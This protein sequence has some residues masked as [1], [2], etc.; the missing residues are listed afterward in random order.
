MKQNEKAC[1]RCAE[2][3]KLDALV[4]KHCGYEFSP[5]EMAAA[6]DAK[7][8][9]QRKSLFGCLGC[10]GLIAI[11]AVIAAVS[12]SGDGSSSSTED[13]KA[14]FVN[15]YKEV[16]S[17]AAPCDRAFEEL[18]ASA[19]TGKIVAVYAAAKAGS[20]SCRG[21]A[22]TINEKSAPAG[23]AIEARTKTDEALTF[24]RNAYLSR[25]SAFENMM[26]IADGEGRTSVQAELAEDAKRGEAGVLMCIGTLFEAA[27]KAGIDTS[28][29]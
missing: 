6:K 26:K 15:L 5:E 20:E 27:G 9:E 14:A 18:K 4:C 25:Q 23:L 29:L 24:C 19:E 8:A 7:Q 2:H 1:P 17:A 12:G 21:A 13:P 16:I 22:M 11:V 28:A 10:G 3:V